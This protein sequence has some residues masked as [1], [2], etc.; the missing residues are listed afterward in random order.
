MT[1][2]DKEHKGG[3]ALGVIDGDPTYILDGAE[4]II[5]AG[6]EKVYFL[7]NKALLGKGEITNSQARLQSPSLVKEIT[8]QQLE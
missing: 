5:G 4:S 1:I 8:I 6:H 7:T 2:F 3:K